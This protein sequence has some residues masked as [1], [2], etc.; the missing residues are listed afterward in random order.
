MVTGPRRREVNGLNEKELQM[1]TKTVKLE[2]DADALSEL[3]V[4]V[5]PQFARLMA[6]TRSFHGADTDGSRRC[7]LYAFL[8][9]HGATPDTY[10]FPE[11]NLPE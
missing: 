5:S 3:L 8:A 2:L 10:R 11:P 7:A 1:K 4:S 9:E 6:H